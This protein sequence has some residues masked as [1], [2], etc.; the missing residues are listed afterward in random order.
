VVE[1]DADLQDAVIE[2]SY[3]GV[4]R[5]PEELERLVLLEEVAGVQL[6]DALE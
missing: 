1:A 6:L 2:R 4:R 3:R 5:A